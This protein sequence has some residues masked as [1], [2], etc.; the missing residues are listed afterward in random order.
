QKNTNNSILKISNVNGIFAKWFISSRFTK[1]L[2]VLVF[3]AGTASMSLEFAASRIL[4][5]VFG[6]SIYTWGSLIGVILTGLSL[7]YHIGGKLADKNPS[8]SKL[9]LVIFSAGLYIIFI[10]F[11]APTI[12]SS[13]IQFVSDS[14]YSSLFAVFALL[15]VPTFLLGI[16]SPYAIKLATRRLAEL[17]NVSGNLYSLSTVGSIVGTF[18]TVF[19]LIPTFEINY[20]I[21]GLGVTLIFFSS[22]FGPARFPKILAVFVVVLL[23]FFPSISL[24]SAGN[25]MVHT[26]T[27][28]YEKET[29]YSHL[30]VIDNGNIRTLYLDGNIHSQMYKDKPEE[31]VN[32]YTKYFHLGFLFNPNTQDVLFVG[33]GGFSG[34]KNFLSMYSD[35]RIDV[36]EID[37]DVISAARDY[38]NL[39][40]D[41]GS[42]LMIYNDDAR[43]FLSKTEK[44]Y[45]LIILDAFSKN[46]VPFHLMTLEYF[47]LLD[48]KLTSDGVIISNNIGSMTGDR[49][50]IVR[51]IY[52]TISQVFPSVYVFYTENN[53][54]N[55]QN[56]MLAAVKT[57]TEY[58]RDELRQLAS[59]ND[60]NNHNSST[61][62][63]DLDY[64]EHLY[65]AE[66]K[67]SDV[68][69]LTDQF[70]P[71][72]ILINPVTNEPYNLENIPTKGSTGLSWIENTNSVKL[73]LLTII[74]AVWIFYTQKE[75]KRNPKPMNL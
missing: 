22:L 45:D 36:V 41:N 28:V 66:L 73:V 47:Q 4:I 48:K 25:V 61:A 72:E 53:S 64:L 18:L 11:I 56:I 38:F 68:P 9:C 2:A 14:Q 60:N 71:V 30:D 50:D 69:L 57:P 5:P 74:A 54:G 58:S 7:G 46:Y 62:L 15:I 75:W 24:S 40:V 39:P 34:P 67:T 3:V 35:V 20:I 52:K 26:G 59:N 10:P 17:G 23:L 51:A 13:F 55:L 21:I 31:L 32:T 63:A 16:V 8:F 6:S 49:S 29:L 1:S 19:I 44:K 43:N 12:T 70:A 65:D 42:R 33:G 27:L 37:P